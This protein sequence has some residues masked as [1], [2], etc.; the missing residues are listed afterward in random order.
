MGGGDIHALA[1]LH[2]RVSPKRG[3][4]PRL[5]PD[6]PRS[7]SL[8]S[9]L[10]VARSGLCP[11]PALAGLLAQA[12]L[13]RYPRSSWP[14]GQTLQLRGPSRFRGSAGRFLPLLRRSFLLR[15]TRPC[16]SSASSWVRA[17]LWAAAPTS[18]RQPPGTFLP[19]APRPA[20]LAARAR[21]PLH[22]QT[23]VHIHTRL[24]C[25][26]LKLTRSRRRSR[27]HRAHALSPRRPGPSSAAS[28][29]G[30]ELPAYSSIKRLVFVL[31]LI[32]ETLFL[33]LFP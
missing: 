15:A 1:G 20:S 32:R 30:P 18:R 3:P 25:R 16:L 7:C 31:G 21:G 12:F 6:A 29:S 22:T 23:R 8:P 5:G 2:E 14:C 19:P 4:G 17:V 33:S 10:A 28:S 11:G 27:P 13:P 26:R 24:T 9:L